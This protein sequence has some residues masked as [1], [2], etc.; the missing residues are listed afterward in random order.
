M[1]YWGGGRLFRQNSILTAAVHNS[2]ITSRFYHNIYTLLGFYAAKTGSVLP[3]YPRKAHISFTPQWWPEIMQNL[4]SKN[5]QS[6]M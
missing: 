5:F 6:F 4:P 1:C 3:T 2:Y